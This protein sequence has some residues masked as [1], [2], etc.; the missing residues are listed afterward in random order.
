M[1]D[2]LRILAVCFLLTLLLS[3]DAT[4]GAETS[5]VEA[6]DLARYWE[7]YDSVSVTTDSVRSLRL[8]NELFIDKAS[9]GQEAL[10]AA[11]RYTPEEYVR[12]I[13]NYPK[14]YA[15]IRSNVQEHDGTIDSL[16]I[17]LARLRKLYPEARPATVYL[18]MGN[19]RTSGTTVD[20][21]VLIGTELAFGDE[22]VDVSELPPE[23][24]YVKDYM[25]TNPVRNIDFLTVHEFVHTQQRESFG[26]SLLASALREGSAEFIAELASGKV[27]SSPALTYG[28]E[29]E[30]DVFAAFRRQLFNRNVGYWLWSSAENDFGVRDLGYYTGYRLAQHYYQHSSDSMLAIRQLIELDYADSTAVTDFVNRIGYFEE[31]MAELEAAYRRD[32]PRVERL[33]RDGNQLTVYFSEAMLPPY[34]GFDYGPLGASAL[35][36][37]TEVIGFAPDSTAITFTVDIR[38]G[39]VQQLTMTGNFRDPGGVELAPYLIEIRPE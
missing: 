8:L 33:V 18:G 19:M 16:D 17:Y 6:S 12:Y 4:D 38:P 35:L 2:I 30:D 22:T 5:A 3:C 21:S 14:Y 10:F 9:D 11:R 1:P 34:R 7:A 23:L 39:E 25:L 36:P 15:S 13:K 37:V 32:Q 24:D 28:K 20:S 26:V 27:S 31:D 29:N